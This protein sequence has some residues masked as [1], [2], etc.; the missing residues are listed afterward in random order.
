MVAEHQARLKADFK[1]AQQCLL[2]PAHRRKECYDQKVH[3][4][5]LRGGQLVYLCDLSIRKCHEIQDIC[6]LVVYQVLKTP[7][8]EGVV[9][10]IAP[11]DDLKKVHDVHCDMLRPRFSLNLRVLS[12]LPW[13]ATSFSRT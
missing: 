9:Y 13:F 8:W 12:L 4:E 10:T 5:P 6:S 3:D 11:A 7:Q 2:L 1:G